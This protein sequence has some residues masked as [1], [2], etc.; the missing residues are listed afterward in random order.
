MVGN[1]SFTINFWDL[2]IQFLQLLMSKIEEK[3]KVPNFGKRSL[4]KMEVFDLILHPNFDLLT[5]L[6]VFTKCHCYLP[7]SFSKVYRAINV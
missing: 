2:Q 4:N 6:K 5:L 3:I 7:L 1:K